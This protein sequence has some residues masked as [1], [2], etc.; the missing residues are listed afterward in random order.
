LPH[1]TNRAGVYLQVVDY[2]SN[3]LTIT[4]SSH[5]QT[6]K[7]VKSKAAAKEVDPIQI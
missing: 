5:P 1:S 2:K 6:C 4:L 3:S 7:N